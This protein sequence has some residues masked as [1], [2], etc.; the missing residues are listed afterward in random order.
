MLHGCT[1]GDGS[2][3]GIKAVLLNQ[4]V[5]GRNCLVGA[6]SLVTERKRF[7]D[8]S[9]IMGAP[10]RHARALTPEEVGRLGL[11][12]QSY[13]DRAVLFRAELERLA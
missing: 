12:A 3:I 4:S 6:C 8:E 9:L 1:I 11:N 7:A 13:V 5:I 10:A 2:L